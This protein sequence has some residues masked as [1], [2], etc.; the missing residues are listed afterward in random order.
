MLV[1]IVNVN[2]ESFK[3]NAVKFVLDIDR[4]NG[5]TVIVS[6]P[7]LHPSET[8]LG[9]QHS[10]SSHISQLFTHLIDIALE[11]DIQINNASCQDVRYLD[12]VF[13]GDFGDND[14]LG[15]CI[16][17]EDSDKVIASLQLVEVHWMSAVRPFSVPKS[18]R[19]VHFDP[20]VVAV[21]SKDAFA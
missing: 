2:P 17:V 10:I 9:R 3:R 8:P 15:T 21:Q 19:S 20:E 7:G 16:G 4:F 6:I 12:H 5:L 14:V 13:G 18:K 1:H 11:H